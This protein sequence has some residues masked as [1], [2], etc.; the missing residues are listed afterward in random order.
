MAPKEP[1]VVDIRLMAVDVA[2]S[3]LHPERLMTMEDST[4]VTPNRMAKEVTAEAS[5]EV[6]T[7]SPIRMERTAWGWIRR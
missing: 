3:R 4:K 1:P 6:I 2:V 7:V 5:R